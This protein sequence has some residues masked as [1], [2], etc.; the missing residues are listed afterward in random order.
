[1]TKFNPAPHDKHAVDPRLAR[2]LDQDLHGT[3]VNGLV[4]TFPASDPVSATQP[5]P[6]RHDR[7]PGRRP[8]ARARRLRPQ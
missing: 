5:A 1:M 4:D 3:L 6:S 8:V 2:R 7:V